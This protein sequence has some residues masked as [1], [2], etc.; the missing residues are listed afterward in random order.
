M[1]LENLYRVILKSQIQAHLSHIQE[2]R[3]IICFNE[4]KEASSSYSS[5]RAPLIDASPNTKKL[6]RAYIE[7]FQHFDTLDSP[8]P[9]VLWWH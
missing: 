6:K 5:Q 2:I 3:C 9:Q 8:K 1:R 7:S 4:V